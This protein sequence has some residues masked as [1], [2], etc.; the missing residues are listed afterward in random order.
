M[1]KMI[2]LSII[3][4]LGFI[5]FS[6]AP[7]KKSDAFEKA[8]MTAIVTKGGSCDTKYETDHTFS[9]CSERWTGVDPQGKSQ[10]KV[11]EKL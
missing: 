8:E 1:K 10:N 5:V 4:A 6:F 2:F 7:I 11:L 9:K 3:L